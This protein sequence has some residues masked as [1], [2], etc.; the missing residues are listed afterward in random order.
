MSDRSQS[1]TGPGHCGPARPSSGAPGALYV[2]ATPIGNL[3]D[4]SMRALRVLKEADLICAE[5][6]R[7]TRKLL[8]RYDIHTP[9]TS[10]HRHTK[11]QKTQALADLLTQGKSLALVSDAGMPGISD[12]GVELIAEAIRVGAAVV[13]V[14][15]PSA[16]LAALVVSGLPTARFAFDGFP[17]RP[18]SARQRFFAEVAR[19]TRTVVLYE[20]PRRAVDT[21]RDL[22]EAAGNRSVAVARELTKSFEEVFRGTLTEAIAHF[23]ANPPRGEITIVVQGASD[24]PVEPPS[25]TPDDVGAAIDEALR[26]GVSV[27][28]AV[29]QVA[30]RTGMRR[31]DVYRIATDR[32]RPQTRKGP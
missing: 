4:I 20:S 19:E 27:R 6:T 29:D 30:A 18:R 23:D 5:D 17:P 15:G 3:E 12:P 24:E 8:S 32:Q 11:D 21:L 7:V 28:D 16:S 14:P 22:H 13:P 26:S 1:G 2:V 25:R 10:W 31:R 9:L